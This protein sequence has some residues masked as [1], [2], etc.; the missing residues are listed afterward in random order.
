[1]VQM[2]STF[3]KEVQMQFYR[4]LIKAMN[5]HDNMHPKFEFHAMLYALSDKGNIK[6][7]T[8]DYDVCIKNKVENF[9]EKNN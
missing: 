2:I 7:V 1:M 6:E 3:N 4:N 8:M 5:M 9:K